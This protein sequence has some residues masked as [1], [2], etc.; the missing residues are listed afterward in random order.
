[1]PVS[2]WPVLIW[3]VFTMAVAV[4][5][6]RRAAV[7][8][9]NS[10]IAMKRVLQGSQPYGRTKLFIEEWRTARGARPAR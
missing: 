4:F 9:N 8:Q 2:V 6:G 3:A 7:R 5:I 10:V 1:M